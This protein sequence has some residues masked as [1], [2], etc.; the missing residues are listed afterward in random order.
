M[1][2]TTT[3]T[4][5]KP[6][7][8]KKDNTVVLLGSALLTGI[9]LYWFLGKKKKESDKPVVPTQTTN[10]STPNVANNV[11][12]TVPTATV[13][14][15][16]NKIFYYARLGQTKLYKNVSKI[17]FITYPSHYLVMLPKGMY[18]GEYANEKIG[19]YLKVKTTLKGIGTFIFWVDQYSVTSS[20]RYNPAK[21]K[22]Q[23]II[24]TFITEND[25]V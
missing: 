24:N 18:V 1:N 25:R 13:K 6:T 4:K 17:G 14:T 8:K 23:G 16:T 3:P 15:P 21:A 5:R 7:P 9:G 19:D 11:Q 20:N 22:T 12:T 2:K 10:I